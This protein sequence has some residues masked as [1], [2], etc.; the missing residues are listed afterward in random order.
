MVFLFLLHV[1][2]H[3]C[4]QDAS[5]LYLPL[6]LQALYAVEITR[7]D[8]EE[9]QVCRQTLQSND[10]Q[11]WPSL[12]SMVPLLRLLTVYQIFAKPQQH[13]KHPEERAKK[14][15]KQWGSRHLVCNP[16]L[17]WGIYSKDGAH[18]EEVNTLS[19]VPSFPLCRKPSSLQTIICGRLNDLLAIVAD[20]H[21][22]MVF[23]WLSCQVPLQHGLVHGN[24]GKI[25]PP[26]KNV[27]MGLLTNPGGWPK[28]WTKVLGLLFFSPSQHIILSKGYR[29]CF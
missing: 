27:W 8:K 28:M 24:L 29:T 14:A 6:R 13:V 18:R 10:H 1:S 17:P 25:L 11:G 23:P 2:L 4:N 3:N 16:P 22:D 21:C 9:S 15:L 12:P 20:I 19:L 7:L 26:L 5:T